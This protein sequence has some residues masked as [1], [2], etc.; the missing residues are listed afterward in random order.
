MMNKDLVVFPPLALKC[1]EKHGVTEVPTIV[2]DVSC[3]VGTYLQQSCT[4]GFHGYARVVWGEGRRGTDHTSV[5][6]VP[7]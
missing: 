7:K 1:H 6:M 3:F 4:G 5:S 2:L